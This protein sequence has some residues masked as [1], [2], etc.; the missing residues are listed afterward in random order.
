MV[1]LLSSARYRGFQKPSFSAAPSLA[2]NHP[3]ELQEEKFY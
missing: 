1:K 2:D 3:G